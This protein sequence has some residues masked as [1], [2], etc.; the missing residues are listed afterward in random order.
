MMTVPCVAFGRF[1]PA[2]ATALARDGA[3]FIAP[4]PEVWSG[5]DPRQRPRRLA[6]CNPR[7]LAPVLRVNLRGLA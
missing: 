2:A 6:G 4:E 7:W 3:D 5:V 1:D